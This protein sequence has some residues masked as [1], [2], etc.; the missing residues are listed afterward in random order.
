M[1]VV[2]RAWFFAAGCLLALLATGLAI[3]GLGEIVPGLLG[4][5]LDT[6]RLLTAIGYV[7]ISV[8]VFDVGKYIIEEEVVRYRELRQVG[9]VRRSLTRFVS[10]IL[11]A[12][13]LES[14]VLVFKVSENEI[15][16]M[17]YPALLLFAGVAMLIG[18]GAFQRLVSAVETERENAGQPEESR[19]ADDERE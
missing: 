3:A 1:I 16:M 4:G 10:T 14:I 9:E 7:V 13:F 12:V 19:T 2:S 6:Q 15:A 8:A 5:K 18:L 11:I 17:T